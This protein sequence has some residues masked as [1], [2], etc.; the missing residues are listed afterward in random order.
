MRPHLPDDKGKVSRAYRGFLELPVPIVLFVLWLAG[1]M[2]ISLC[3][4][5]LYL[6]WLLL[7]VAGR[8]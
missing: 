5:A 1:A 6:L 4:L 2:L 8:A 7:R 3:A